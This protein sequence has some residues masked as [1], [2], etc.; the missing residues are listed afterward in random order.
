M[1]AESIWLASLLVAGCG[2]QESKLSN[3]TEP[4]TQPS[5]PAVAAK[6]CDILTQADASKALGR[7]VTK[8][9]ASG[10]AGGYDI[11][12]YGYQGERM[13]D[14]GNVSVTVHPVD[15]AS[16]KQ[17]VLAEGYKPEPVPGVGDEAFWTREAGLYVGKGNRSAIYLLGI[18]GASD[19]QN[20]AKAI[21]L[22]KA[23]IGRL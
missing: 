10:G 18:G 8:L 17:G 15:L 3:A 19:E 21:E 9:D 11:C 23:T 22:A 1:R 12:Q 14:S 5:G 16:L 20:R 13:M 2:Q 6:A 4:A 7:D